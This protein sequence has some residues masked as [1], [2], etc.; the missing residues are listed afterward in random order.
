MNIHGGD[1]MANAHMHSAHEQ[2]HSPTS[3]ALAEGCQRC[4]QS[5]H[6]LNITLKDTDKVATALQT[7]Y[8]SQNEILVSPQ[9]LQQALYELLERFKMWSGNCG[10]HRIGRASLDHRLREAPEIHQQVLTLLQDLE[11]ALH[12]G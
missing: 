8:S 9:Q 7:A 12:E 1:G 2:V 6:E 10:A 5:F 4:F 3:T 11:N